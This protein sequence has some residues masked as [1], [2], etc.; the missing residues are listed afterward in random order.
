MAASPQD[1]DEASG[2]GETQKPGPWDSNQRTGKKWEKMVLF[3]GIDMD[4]YG[5]LSWL[6]RKWVSNGMGGIDEI[7]DAHWWLVSKVGCW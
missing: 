3:H 4:N 1:A 7:A 2:A 6:G 5:A